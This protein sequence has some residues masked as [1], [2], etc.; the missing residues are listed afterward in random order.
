MGW[1]LPEYLDLTPVHWRTTK[2]DVAAVTEEAESLKS[3][4]SVFLQLLQVKLTDAND[5]R[6]FQ[7]Y[8]Q[9]ISSSPSRGLEFLRKEI[10]KKDG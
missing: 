2:I 7:M 4:V 1:V 10:R 3:I 9:Q 5:A 6:K 8:K